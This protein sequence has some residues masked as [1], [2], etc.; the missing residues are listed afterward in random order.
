VGRWEAGL[1]APEDES[2]ECDD[3]IML[4]QYWSAHWDEEGSLTRDCL[5]PGKA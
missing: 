1:E 5:D 2:G 4:E 3:L